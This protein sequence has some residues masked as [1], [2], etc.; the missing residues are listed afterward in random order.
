MADA[1]VETKALV[2]P[3]TVNEVIEPATALSK[4]DELLR[5]PNALTIPG[6]E[7]K[8]AVGILKNPVYFEADHGMRWFN[9]TIPLGQTEEPAIK[10]VVYAAYLM[11]PEGEKDLRF[12]TLP[13]VLFPGKDKYNQRILAEMASQQLPEGV[14]KDLTQL[15]EVQHLTSYLDVRLLPSVRFILGGGKFL[16]EQPHPEDNRLKLSSG[17]GKKRLTM[18]GDLKNYPGNDLFAQQGVYS[19]FDQYTGERYNTGFTVFSKPFTPE[20]LG[21]FEVGLLNKV[22]KANS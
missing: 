4:V 1:P 15:S 17:W 14:A 7:G 5:G 16:T 2:M 6:S 18:L 11:R 22:A 9:V 21:N 20:T 12:L 3:G 8:T 13:V 10:P 19:H